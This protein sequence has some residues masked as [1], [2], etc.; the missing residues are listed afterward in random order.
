[1]RELLFA[2]ALLLVCPT[3]ALSYERQPTVEVVSMSYVDIQKGIT[4][5]ISSNYIG[6]G[7]K[8]IVITLY[9]PA[10]R[11]KVEYSSLQEAMFFNSREDMLFIAY[12]VEIELKCE[13]C[14]VKTGKH[15]IPA[16]PPMQPVSVQFLLEVNRTAELTLKIKYERI[17]ELRELN[18]FPEQLIPMERTITISNTTVYPA[19]LTIQNSTRYKYEILAQKYELEYLS[20]EKEIP[21]KFYVEEENVILEVIELKAENL[22]AGGKGDIELKIKNSGRKVAK[23]AY[24][25]LELPKSQSSTQATMPT[26]TLPISMFSIQSLPTTATTQQQV[27]SYYI[28]DLKP[29]EVKKAQFHISLDVASGGVYPVKAKLVY[30]DE[31]GNLKESDPVTFGIKILSKPQISVISTESS[32]YVNSK[33]DLIIEMISNANLQ[34][35]SAR[36][37]VSAPISALSTECYI[38]DIEA[39]KN[40]SAVFRLKASNEA[41]ATKYPA[42]IYLK[43][44]AGEEYIETDAVKIGIEVKPEI[45]FE[46]LGIPE[47]FAGEEKIIQFGVKNLGTAEVKDATARLFA[48]SPFSSS[49]DTAF[50]GALKPGEVANVS[51]KVM[52]ERDATPKLYALNLEVKYRA[53]NGEWI[54]SKPS[55]AVINVKSMPANYLLYLIVIVAIVG[56]AIYYLRKRR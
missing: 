37:S 5:P 9:N 28:G 2:L 6:K 44:K 51:F 19:N 1:M 45:E 43:F 20:E 32:V 33:G 48:V 22:I 17:N 3:M 12:N 42:E 18:P 54:I 49:D 52:V 21:I 53:E 41:K 23:N 10:L 4:T 14:I 39:G 46:V 25:T 13:E 40:F 11:E 47:I 35:A 30:T 56:G 26:A 55:K 34:D 31:Y 7:E 27:P 24:L 50:I 36:I 15:R 8:I 29:G 16:L 38:G